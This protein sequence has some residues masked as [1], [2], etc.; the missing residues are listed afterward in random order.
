MVALFSEELT[1]WDVYSQTRNRF[2]IDAATS[3]HIPVPPPIRETNQTPIAYREE[4][5]R[6]GHLST[7]VQA[8][9]G[10]RFQLR[11]LTIPHQRPVS[12]SPLSGY[13]PRYGGNQYWREPSTEFECHSCGERFSSKTSFEVS[14]FRRRANYRRKLPVHVLVPHAGSQRLQHETAYVEFYHLSVIFLKI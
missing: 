5:R 4:E 14:T 12:P 13:G 11:P 7:H 6:S 8:Q 1:S 10:G 2:Y 3:G 9:A